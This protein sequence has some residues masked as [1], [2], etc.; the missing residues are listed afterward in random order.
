MTRINIIVK[1]KKALPILEK[2]RSRKLIDYGQ[3]KRKKDKIQTH[4]ASEKVLAKDW[5]SKKEDKAWQDL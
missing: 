3:S 1:D 2:L 5:L 4:L